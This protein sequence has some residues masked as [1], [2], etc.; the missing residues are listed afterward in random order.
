MLHHHGGLLGTRTLCICQ[1]L[2]ERELRGTSLKHRVAFANAGRATLQQVAEWVV[3]EAHRRGIAVSSDTAARIVDAA[4]GMRFRP[5]A[6][7]SRRDMHAVIAYFSPVGFHRPLANLHTVLSD[8]LAAGIPVTVAE[9]VMPGAEPL[10]LP[11]G[12]QH[13]RWET[14]SVLFLK[15]NLFNLSLPYIDEPKVLQLDGDVRFLSRR[16]WDRTSEALDV[17]DIVQPFDV[18]WWLGPRGGVHHEKRSIVEAFPSRTWPDLRI[19]HPGFA[20]AFR[21]EW[22]EAVG[23]IYDL[24]AVGGGDTALAFALAPEQ[25]SARTLGHWV[26]L[27]NLF[28]ET[29][30]FR[31]WMKRVRDTGC[32]IDYLRRSP[33]V[34]LFHGTRDRR[35]YD[36]RSVFL[37]S[38]VDGEYPIRRRADGL[39]EWIDPRHSE[40]LLEYFRSREEDE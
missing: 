4:C 8:L 35:R 20:W 30:T 9:A 6:Q 12:V 5:Y 21:R 40:R 31:L 29:T 17:V 27:E 32:S 23:G 1:R 7:A 36:D 16:W 24:H 25:P 19:F 15:E 14:D 13:L 28:H 22:L 11:E 10:V 26:R 37:P 39:L 38:L 3:E 2:A 33:L 34:H 18:C